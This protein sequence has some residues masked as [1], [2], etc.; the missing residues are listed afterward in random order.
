MS[1]KE[2]SPSLRTRSS[3]KAKDN[4]VPWLLTS[5]QKA[6]PKVFSQINTAHQAVS[7]QAQPDTKLCN[8]WH[9]W[10]ETFM[11]TSLKRKRPSNSKL[12]CAQQ[13]L[14]RDGQCPGDAGFC[15]F[16]TLTPERSHCH[17]GI[18][19]QAPK[20]ARAHPRGAPATQLPS[21][22]CGSPPQR[23]EWLKFFQGKRL[24]AVFRVWCQLWDLHTRRHTG[25]P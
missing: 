19:P 23:V 17:S 2:R 7:L 20:H 9:S 3:H 6:T 25:H 8:R 4:K 10:K 5:C 24:A 1:G 22:P 15:P 13:K 12:S 14:V 18:S 16:R 21:A 11:P